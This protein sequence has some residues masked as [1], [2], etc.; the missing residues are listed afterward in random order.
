MC[1]T[2]GQV[3]SN[4]VLVATSCAS[5][6]RGPGLCWLRLHHVSFLFA[7]RSITLPCNTLHCMTS[8]LPITL[9]S[10]RSGDKPPTKSMAGGSAAAVASAALEVCACFQVRGGTLDGQLVRAQFMPRPMQRQQEARREASVR[11]AVCSP[12]PRTAGASNGIRYSGAAAHAQAGL[13]AR[14]GPG[15]E[16][17][18]AARPPLVAAFRQS[19]ILSLSQAFDILI[20]AFRRSGSR[21]S[22]GARDFPPMSLP[23]YQLFCLVKEVIYIL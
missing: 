18:N 19:M 20:F 3:L 11:S 7:L 23:L 13:H 6:H 15:N 10:P 12:L 9:P 22:G 17:D 8:P 21:P 4:A 16:F 5:L 2:T 1:T 14:T